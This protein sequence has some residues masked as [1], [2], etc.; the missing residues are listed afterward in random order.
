MA[1]IAAI[2]VAGR[3]DSASPQAGQ[4][5]ELDAITAVIIGGASFLGGRGRVVNVLAGALIIGVI[6]NGLDLLERQPVLAADRDRHARDRVARARRRCAAGSRRGCAPRVRRGRGMTPLLE[7]RGAVKSYGAVR[8]LDGASLTV[9][10]GRGRRAARRQRRG[11]VDADQGDQRRPHARRGR[12]PRRR[13][14]R[15]RSARRSRRARA[16]IE[17]LHQD[18]GLFDNLSAVANFRI[19]REL[20]RPRWL[21]RLALLRERAMER[22]LA[23]AARAARRRSRRRRGRR[24]G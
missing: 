15:S 19:G 20:R 7:V 18:L 16:G 10:R 13:A 4:L 8:A 5:L 14:T 1:G 23:R 2:L 22:R 17:T 21:G 11:Q 3:T 12:D 6:R 9:E 24:S